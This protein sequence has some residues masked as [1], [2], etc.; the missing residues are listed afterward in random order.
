M[1]KSKKGNG[2]VRKT[3]QTATDT[4]REK[5]IRTDWKDFYKN[6]KEKYTVRDQMSIVN[7]VV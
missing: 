2:S 4:E 1:E 6:V 5:S 3:F 7:I